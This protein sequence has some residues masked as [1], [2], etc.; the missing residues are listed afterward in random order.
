M[1]KQFNYESIINPDD[2]PKAIDETVMLQR[3]SKQGRAGGMTSGT[4][5]LASENGKYN[6]I[7]RKQKG[8]WNLRKVITTE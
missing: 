7:Y 3:L 4:T 1:L 6:G 8:I 2:F 5:S